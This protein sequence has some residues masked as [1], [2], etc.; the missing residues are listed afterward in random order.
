MAS[1][2][3]ISGAS[4]T[5]TLGG[6]PYPITAWTV[7]RKAET[8]E[9]TDSNSSTVSEFIPEGHSSWDGTMEGWVQDGTA[10]LT[11]GAAA[12]ALVLTAVTGTYWTGNAIITGASIVLQVK[13]S[14]AVKVSY[15]F[16][17]TGALV[18]TNA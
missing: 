11:V 15:T 5:M 9:V 10:C 18:E 16:Q 17:G 2:V 3:T 7:N 12:A 14:D 8:R 6:S 1:T 13:G 4:G